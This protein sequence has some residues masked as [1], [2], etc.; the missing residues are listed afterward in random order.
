MS[1]LAFDYGDHDCIVHNVSNMIGDYHWPAK[2]QTSAFD[3]QDPVG[4]EK[5]LKIELR[6]PEKVCV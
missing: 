5:V 4:C 6:T 1:W 2:S 3:F